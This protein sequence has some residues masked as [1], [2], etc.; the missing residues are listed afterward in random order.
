MNKECEML[1]QWLPVI[2]KTQTSYL[3]PKVLLAHCYRLTSFPSTLPMPSLLETLCL[4]V[5]QT[6]QT[7][8]CLRTFALAGPV[9]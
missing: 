3:G 4:Y 5:P 6:H 1:D 2:L 7:P 9:A 8:A